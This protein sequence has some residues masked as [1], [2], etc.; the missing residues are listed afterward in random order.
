M[1]KKLSALSGFQSRRCTQGVANGWIAIGM[2]LISVALVH[3]KKHPA[4]ISV[5]LANSHFAKQNE[6]IPICVRVEKT[7]EPCRI[8][9]EVS[10]TLSIEFGSIRQIA[11]M[12]GLSNSIPSGRSASGPLGTQA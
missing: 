11:K 10:T 8:L 1:G 5:S 9:S 6:L 2:Q 12:S 3:L 7:R 4:A